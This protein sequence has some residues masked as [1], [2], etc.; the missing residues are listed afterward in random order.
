MDGPMQQTVLQ[1][2]DRSDDP[3]RHAPRRM[4]LFTGAPGRRRWP[5][6]LKALIVLESLAPD[7]VVTQVAQR[8]GCRAQQIHDWRRLA[9]T[10]ALALPAPVVSE[11]APA[12]VPI[13]VAP[14][15]PGPALPAAS[16]SFDL[17][18]EIAGA[19]V[20]VRGRTD[21]GVLT[22]V[23]TALRRSCGC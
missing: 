22:D 17:E 14:E 12:F 13:V 1:T 16:A 5:D 3:S 19:T 4:E 10:G 8:H 20:R 9:R 21:I 7:A 2:D 23:F 11:P 18:V 15:A 6:E